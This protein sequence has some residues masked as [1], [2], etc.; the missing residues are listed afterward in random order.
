MGVISVPNLLLIKIRIF[1]KKVVN[2]FS[3]MAW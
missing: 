2:V 1:L 3:N